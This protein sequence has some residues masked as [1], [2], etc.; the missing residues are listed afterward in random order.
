MKKRKMKMGEVMNLSEGIQIMLDKNI[1]LNADSGF[2]IMLTKANIEKLVNQV[3][4]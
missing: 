4:K 3:Y 2:D 1:E